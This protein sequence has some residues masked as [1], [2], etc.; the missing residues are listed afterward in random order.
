MYKKNIFF[1]TENKNFKSDLNVFEK[2]QNSQ[3]VSLILRKI[4]MIKTFI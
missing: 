3:F 4:L 1:N 2:N